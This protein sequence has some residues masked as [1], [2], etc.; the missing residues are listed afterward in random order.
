MQVDWRLEPS[1]GH[2]IL[3]DKQIHRLQLLGLRDDFR[4]FWKSSNLDG[5]LDAI[6]PADVTLCIAPE[7]GLYDLSLY[8]VCS[9]FT[10]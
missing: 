5:V 3:S 7:P 4:F 10:N 1:S 6:F 2:E 8:E 9:H